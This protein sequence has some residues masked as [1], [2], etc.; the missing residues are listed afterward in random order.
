VPLFHMMIHDEHYWY[1]KLLGAAVPCDDLRWT[2]YIIK[3]LGA[4]VHLM[5]YDEH[6]I[7]LSY[8]V[9]LFH[10]MVYDEYYILLSYLV[11]LFHVMIYDEH[12]ILLSYLVLLFHV[13]V[14]DKHYSLYLVTLCCFCYVVLQ[15]IIYT[16]GYFDSCCCSA[17]S[18]IYLKQFLWLLSMF[19]ITFLTP[20]LPVPSPD[21]KGGELYKGSA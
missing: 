8:L 16:Y 10:V 11:L 14:Y 4:A 2:L 19:L 20:P 1:I 3:L 18:L 12:Y 9:L 15:T 17:V 21:E 7:L 13:M 6:Y 5:I